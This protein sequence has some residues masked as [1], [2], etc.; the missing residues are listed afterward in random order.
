MLHQTGCRVPAGEHRREGQDNL[1]LMWAG[2]F[3]SAGSSECRACPR[4]WARG[5]DDESHTC[6]EC[7]AGL[8]QTRVGQ[9]ICLPCVPGMYQLNSTTCASC[10]AGF[11]ANMSRLEWCYACRPGT[12]ADTASAAA[13]TACGAGRF[14]TAWATS[15]SC[16]GC[17]LGFFGSDTKRTI[18]SACPAGYYNNLNGSTSCVPIPPG[19]AGQSEC[20][21][22][23]FCA[24]GNATM[25]PC[26]PGKYADQE[27]TA[28]CLECIPGRYAGSSG[29]KRARNVPSFAA[30]RSAS[31]TCRYCE[32][33]TYA[34]AGSA[35]CLACPVRSSSANMTRSEEECF[36][37]E[38]YWSVAGICEECPPHAFCA[39][40]CTAPVTVSG[41]WKVP[42]RSEDHPE[43]RLECLSASACL[44]PTE[45]DPH[46][47][48]TCAPLH[49][50]PLCA[51]C[52]RG[53]YR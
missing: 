6:T 17:P 22:G 12:Y 23:Y 34:V 51:A 45:K 36:C 37:E 38:N 18:C 9:A 39:R 28:R 26:P 52:S 14:G 25:Q 40:N 13:C 16:D 33:G 20:N 27:Q 15:N 5:A 30:P 41:F 35:S 4:G 46:A 21:A 24:G 2:K 49:H 48:S 44:G 32:G 42:W 47:N 43:S 50:G 11:F 53:S 1:R 19:T 10:P 3:K 7:L 8:Y 29:S 31:E